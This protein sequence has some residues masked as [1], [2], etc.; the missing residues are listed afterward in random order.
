MSALA[1]E[2]QRIRELVERRDGRATQQRIAE[3]SREVQ[4]LRATVARL[5]GSATARGYR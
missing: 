3:L 4:Q 2:I 1:S 5:R